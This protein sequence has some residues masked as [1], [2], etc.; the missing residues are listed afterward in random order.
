M[1][2][3]LK[4]RRTLRDSNAS[5]RLQRVLR[6]FLLS[7]Q[8]Y[9]HHRQ[10]KQTKNEKKNVSAKCVAIVVIVNLNHSLYFFCI[11]TLQQNHVFV[12][13]EL[14]L[15]CWVSVAPPTFLHCAVKHCGG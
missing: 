10:V 12:P 5:F 7:L 8:D 13:L 1:L 15:L 3:D 2:T 11:N 6:L 14:P 4:P 9:N